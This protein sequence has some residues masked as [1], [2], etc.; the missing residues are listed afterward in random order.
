MDTQFLCTSYDCEIGGSL[1]R[2]V[3]FEQLKTMPDQVLNTAWK[4]QHISRLSAMY[5]EPRGHPYLLFCVYSIESNKCKVATFQPLGHPVQSHTIS[6]ATLFMLQN[7][8]YKDFNFDVEINGLYID[9]S[10][11][12]NNIEVKISSV[13]LLKEA[14]D[15]DIYKVDNTTYGFMKTV[16]LKSMTTQ[17]I[18]GLCNSYQNEYQYNSVDNY[19][20]FD[21]E[22]HRVLIVHKNKIIRLPD[23]AAYS[24]IY[25]R[26]NYITSLFTM[27][28]QL[29]KIQ[30]E[31]FIIGASLASSSQFYMSDTDPFKKGFILK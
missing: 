21:S 24:I 16:D 23:T 19:I 10:T 13:N 15:I 9:S 1:F 28:N 31:K 8:M 6:Q 20:Y 14:R 3:P 22:T 17:D 7:T 2:F 26:Y 29:I 11:Q 30:N 25:H 18:L 5:S 4:D 12:D 27:T